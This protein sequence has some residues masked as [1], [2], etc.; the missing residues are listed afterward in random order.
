MVQQQIRRLQMSPDIDPEE[1]AIPLPP[2]YVNTSLPTAKPP[3]IT[4]R[5]KTTAGS[6]SPLADG[7]AKGHALAF[8]DPLTVEKVPTNMVVLGHSK[9]VSVPVDGIRYARPTMLHNSTPAVAWKQEGEA[10]VQTWVQVLTDPVRKYTLDDADALAELIQRGSITAYRIG[11]I[12][13]GP[14]SWYDNATDLPDYAAVIVA[15]WPLE[16]S[17][18]D[19]EIGDLNAAIAEAKKSGEDAWKVARKAPANQAAAVEKVHEH[20]RKDYRIMHAIYIVFIAVL[21]VICFLLT[22]CHPWMAKS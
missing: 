12:I 9:R 19:A 16:V 1:P 6:L 8:G 15:N 13:V 21:V 2:N 17:R 4:G 5:V 10:T 3:V 14:E 7:W 18:R 20:W 11:K 22:T